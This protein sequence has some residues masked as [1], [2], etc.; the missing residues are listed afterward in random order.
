MLRKS[1]DADPSIHK[2]TGE[3]FASPVSISFPDAFRPS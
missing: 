1:G 3:A 2:K